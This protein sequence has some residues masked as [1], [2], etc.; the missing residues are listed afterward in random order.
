M[1]D[2]T[3][4]QARTL[5]AFSRE[6][7]LQ[8]AAKRLHKTHSSVLYALKQ[9]ETQ[10]G[11]GLFDRSGYR[12]RLTAA[13]EAVLVHCRSM[14]EAERALE[15]TCAVLQSGWEPV[16]R[17]VFDAI[18]PLTPFL[19]WVREVRREKAPTRVVL[20]AESLD[21][22]AARFEAERA[23]VMVTVLPVDSSP[24]L[25]VKTL[26]KLKAQLVAHRSH[27]LAKER[28]LTR[29]SL[30]E[31]VLL[32][33]RGSDPRL[34]LATAELD[35]QSMVHLS[36]FHAKKDAILEGLGFG[37]L[38]EW[39]MERELKRGELK[40]LAIGAGSAHTFQPRAVVRSA[41]AG[42]ATRALLDELALTR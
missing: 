37:W 11:L 35:R 42:K 19:S 1:L 20:S 18:V 39:M 12:T 17:V 26:A 9:L 31:H 6:R 23:Q 15:A 27:P 38:P 13:G 30:S 41:N 3:L 8:A 24:S 25:E 16:V 28:H 7:T 34:Q 10:T 32:T 36:D 5:D 40:A 4:E 33:V 2:V 14:L 21:G 29:A 22:V